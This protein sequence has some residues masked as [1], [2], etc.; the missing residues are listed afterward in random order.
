MP[1][2]AAERRWLAGQRRLA[3][4][5]IVAGAPAAG[6]RPGRG[7]QLGHCGQSSPAARR[8]TRLAALARLLVVDAWTDR[9]RT[10]LL[11]AAGDPRRLLTVGLA[12]PEYTVS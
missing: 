10:A 12:S 2:R 9:T 11:E 3:H 5:V 1:L 7:G 8:T 6:R 4:H